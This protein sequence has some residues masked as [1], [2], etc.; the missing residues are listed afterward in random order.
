MNAGGISRTGDLLDLAE[1]HGVV[2]K[3]GSFYK[4]DGQVLAQGRE[5]AKDV[6]AGDPKLF[7]AIKTKVVEIL[8]AKKP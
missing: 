8:S 3:S 1:E 2:E 6:L 7:G 4:F 5:G